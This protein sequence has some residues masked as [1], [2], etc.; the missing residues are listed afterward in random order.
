MIF[1]SKKRGRAPKIDNMEIRY[2]IRVSDDADK[3][4][5]KYCER[6]G[7][8]KSDLFREA[9]MEKMSRE[10]HNVL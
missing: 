7:K 2:S 5:S 3:R 9:V 6:T 8:N 1:V 10:K 4:I